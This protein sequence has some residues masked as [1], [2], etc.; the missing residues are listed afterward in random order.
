[1]IVLRNNDMLNK[2]GRSTREK[3]TEIRVTVD[4]E[5][6]AMG[7]RGK[8]NSLSH[9][10]NIHCTLTGCLVLGWSRSR[11]QTLSKLKSRVLSRY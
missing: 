4:V 3:R 5:L 10:V 11:K 9:P 2:Y 8:V 1:M 7:M 6:L